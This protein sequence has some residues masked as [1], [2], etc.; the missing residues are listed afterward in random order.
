M[1]KKYKIK[2]YKSIRYNLE[3]HEER[4]TSEL[5]LQK[6]WCKS[7]VEWCIIT[8][9]DGYEYKVKF[10]DLELIKRKK[11]KLKDKK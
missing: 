1:Q 2:D 3:E 7:N 10:E 9:V 4:L 5:T 6:K 11:T 8:S